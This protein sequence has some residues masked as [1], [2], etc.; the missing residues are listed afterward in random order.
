[1]RK[2][3][4]AILLILCVAIGGVLVTIY[5]KDLSDIDRTQYTPTEISSEEETKKEIQNNCRLLLNGKEI[6]NDCYVNINFEQ[7]YAELPL[8]KILTEMGASVVW[9]DK[10]VVLI[11]M[12][13]NEYILN[14]NDCTL[15][16]SDTE[17]NYLALA[18]GANHEMICK[19]VSGEFICDSDT[20][21][22]FIVYE[23]GAKMNIDY[24][25]AII[26]I[27]Y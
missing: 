7:R 14:V 22:Y 16:K 20:S 13:N 2:T 19:T 8:I 18:P 27:E 5:K 21:I 10:F 24:D 23:I 1:M 25:N 15:K 17:S 11:N 26:T 3:V 6:G 4:G 12:N 9:Q